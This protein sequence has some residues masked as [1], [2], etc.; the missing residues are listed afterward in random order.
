MQLKIIRNTIFAK[1]SKI[2]DL[3]LFLGRLFNV[4]FFDLIPLKRYYIQICC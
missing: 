4:L 2:E 1:D 3:C